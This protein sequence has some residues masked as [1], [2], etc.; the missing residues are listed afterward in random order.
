MKTLLRLLNVSHDRFS[1][2]IA[3]S[4]AVHFAVFGM[5]FIQANLFPSQPVEIQR[6]IR[7]DVVA[8]PDIVRSPPPAPAPPAP[9]VN[10]PKPTPK[11]QPKPEPPKPKPKPKPTPKPEPR[12][13]PRQRQ[14][15]Q[16]QA[17]ERMAA[18]QAID[19]LR[20]EERGRPAEDDLVRGNIINEGNSLTGLDRIEFER[21]FG[22]IESQLRQNWNLPRWLADANLRASALVA[23]D[24]RGFVVRKEIMR[25]SG[26]EVF[27]SHV[28]NAIDLSSPFPAPPARLRSMLRSGGIVFNFP[29]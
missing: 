2:F 13:D 20:Q 25:S 27:D 24:E 28:V 3:Y 15:T 23:I 16:R 18:M 8:L 22:E 29:D 19:N 26:N 4:V 12:P 6:A 21:Y 10:I 9:K 1:V 11:P 7:V 14:E 17:L 5:V